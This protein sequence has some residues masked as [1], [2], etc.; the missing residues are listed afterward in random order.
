[1]ERQALYR[2]AEARVDSK[3][4]QALLAEGGESLRRKVGKEEGKA[5]ST[6]SHNDLKLQEGAST[7]K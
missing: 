6:W 2:K 7:G 3:Y 5:S 4:L 1:M